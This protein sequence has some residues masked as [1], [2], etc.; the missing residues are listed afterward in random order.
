MLDYCASGVLPCTA[1]HPITAVCSLTAPVNT[2]S[3]P[4]KRAAMHAGQLFMAAN[5]ANLLSLNYGQ[6]KVAGRDQTND[7]KDTSEQF[8]D[9][10]VEVFL[11]A[12]GA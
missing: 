11:P 10:G 2:R 12:A 6:Q 1:R 4:I 7:I 8:R 5:K 3:H 9:S